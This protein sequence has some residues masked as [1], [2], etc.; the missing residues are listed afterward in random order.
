[1][2]RLFGV[3]Y[4]IG[5]L[6]MLAG[7]IGTVATLTIG[8]TQ[9]T[10]PIRLCLAGSLLLLPEV[11]RKWRAWKK[12]L[13]EQVRERQQEA[14]Q[15]KQQAEQTEQARR[16]NAQSAFNLFL[17]EAEPLV[18]PCL[19]AQ[20][21]RV[22][23]QPGEECCVLT[24]AA[25]HVTTRRTSPVKRGD[26]VSIRLRRGMQYEIE[27]YRGNPLA[28]VSE[29]VTGHGALYVTNHRVVFDGSRETLTIPMK[30]IQE[31]HLD[32][33]R[34]ILFVEQHLHPVIFHISERYRA[35]VL[36]A[37]MFRM[38]ERQRG[39]GRA[40]A[41]AAASGPAE[42]AQRQSKREDAPTTEHQ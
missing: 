5:I 28:D 22:S 16:N 1:M 33:D 29:R 27:G 18:F 17:G 13:A 21:K 7:A 26:R 35:P 32:G 2:S 4:A 20:V 40:E 30:K 39:S 31:V 10:L 38:A 41:A 8:Q 36:A 15:R 11:I 6:V 34:I 37:A 42:P 23:L 25:E 14:A 24:Q 9:A 12:R 19:N 3:L